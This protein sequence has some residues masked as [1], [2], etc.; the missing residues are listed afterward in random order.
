MVEIRGF[1]RES[2]DESS[3][4]FGVNLNA[5]PRKAQI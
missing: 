4:N 5:N 2:S 3:V 1:W